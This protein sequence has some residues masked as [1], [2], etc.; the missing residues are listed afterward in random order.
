MGKHVIASTVTTDHKFSKK[1]KQEKE[2]KAILC[3]NLRITKTDIVLFDKFIM[4]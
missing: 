3:Y 1:D 4:N 2:L